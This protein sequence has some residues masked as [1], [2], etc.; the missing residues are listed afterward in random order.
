LTAPPAQHLSSEQRALTFIADTIDWYRHRPTIQRIGTEP[1]DLLFLEDN[2][3]I[4]TEIVRLSFEFGKAVAAMDAPE[5]SLDPSAAAPGAPA[6]NSRVHDL[7]TAKSKLDGNTQR[8]ADELKSVTQAR[9]T[10]RGADRKKLDTQLAEIRNRI[11]LLKAMSESLEQLLGLVQAASAG[12]DRA[13]NLA[14]LVENLERTVPDVSASNPSQISNIPAD[15]SRAPYGISGMINRASTLAHKERSIDSAIERT[16]ALMK[17]LRNVRTPFMELRKQFPTLSSEAE[18]LDILQRQQSRLADLVARAQKASPAV[19]AVNKQETLLNLY[20][21]HLSEWRSEVRVKVRA[22]W[23]AL[24]VRLGILGAAIA[25]VLGVGV[26]GRRLTYRHVNDADTRKMLLTGER[27]LLWLILILIALFSFAFDLSSL[28]TFLGLLSAGLAV[29]LHDVLLALGGYLLIVRKF[30]V[31]VGDRVQIS[32][33]TG[34]VTNLG[35]MQ[36]ELSE[37]DAAS[38]QRT[39]R[40]AFFANSY[41]FVSPATPLFRQLTATAR[42]QTRIQTPRGAGNAGPS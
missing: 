18:S 2:R 16:N 23:K 38:G 36:F 28:A 29:G 1:A 6:A 10:A 33:V 39:G 40:V 24:I 30:H 12:P 32:G 27:V 35:L 31:R 26:A 21:T 22:A 5:N 15:P 4:T 13:T 14:A 17:S 34:E 3:P 11:R 9:L 37:I 42:L 20:M 41:V 8:A 25:M 19:A 7:I